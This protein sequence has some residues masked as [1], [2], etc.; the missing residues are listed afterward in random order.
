[1]YLRPRLELFCWAPAASEQ[2]TTTSVAA[3]KERR[4]W[5]RENMEV[6][7]NGLHPDGDLSGRQL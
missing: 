4:T 6:I 5:E 7:V 2:Q 1:L 3:S